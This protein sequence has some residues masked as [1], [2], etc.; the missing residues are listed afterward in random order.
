M[1]NGMIVRRLF[2]ENVIPACSTAA[3]L[4]AGN[5]VD[6][7]VTGQCLGK[8]AV[9]AFGLANPILLGVIGLSGMLGVGTVIEIGQALGEGEK[10]RV[11][12]VFASSLTAGAACGMLLMLLLFAFSDRIASIIGA[13]ELLAVPASDYL[14]GY[15]F[16][17]P[18]FFF[19][20]ILGF[21]MPLDGDKERVVT[22]M[23]ISTAVNI[24]LDLLNGFVLHMGLYGMALATSI[25]YWAE[26]AVLLLHFRRK[27]KLFRFALTPFHF[28]AVFGIVE[29]GIPYAL[30]LLMRMLGVILINR[31]ILS[32]SAMESVAVFSLL[33]SSANLILIDGTA[34]G[35]T[36][37]TVENC[38]VGE[39]DYRSVTMLMKT[40]A[41]HAVVVNLVLSGVFI[42]TAPWILRLF[43]RDPTIC[44]PAIH[45]FRLFATC[46]VIYALNY[47]FRSHLQSIRRIT[48]SVVYA[49]FDVLIGPVAAAFLLSGLIGLDGIWLCYTVGELLALTGLFLCAVIRSRKISLRLSD[50]LFLD[51]EWEKE[52]SESLILSIPNKKEALLQVPEASE[53]AIRFLLQHGADSRQANLLGLCAEEIGSNIVRHGFKKP[54]HALELNLKKR[55]NE[56]ILSI[57]DNCAY[58][59]LSD[60]LSIQEQQKE[61]F[62]LRIVKGLVHDVEYMSA[63]KINHVVIRIP[64]QADAGEESFA[65]GEE[66]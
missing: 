10:E 32:C 12:T 53:E 2:H 64:A 30:Q 25:S 51:P 50:Y 24:A 39:R 58:F 28:R 5:I 40:A 19:Q 23:A 31:I 57:R 8:T 21:V 60:Y 47:A 61:K 45:A 33:M 15:S 34:V 9:A 44:E 46:P 1:E 26:F 52:D 17:I 7:V 22:A 20:T 4:V 66:E 36:V 62:G 14:K 41:I 43:T 49:A 48:F 16:G 37:L 29:D 35:T 3:V 59:N 18:A 6:A 54:W 11:R 56:W 42:L 13:D 27:D 38:F 55:L 65:N 63:L